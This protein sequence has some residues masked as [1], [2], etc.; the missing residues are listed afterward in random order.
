MW[1]S[2]SSVQWHCWSIQ[3]LSEELYSLLVFF[4]PRE[5]MFTDIIYSTAE[6]KIYIYAYPVSPTSIPHTVSFWLWTYSHIYFYLLHYP[7][8]PRLMK[9]QTL[10]S[11]ISSSVFIYCKDMVQIVLLEGT[12]KQQ[13]SEYCEISRSTVIITAMSSQIFLQN[14]KSEIPSWTL[15][16]N[17]LFFFPF[18]PSLKRK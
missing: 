5:G 11:L 14:E 6:I 12:D 16:T 13:F 3:N 15:A 10:C 7:P 18:F 17:L 9:R 1:L 8:V 4:F 2:L